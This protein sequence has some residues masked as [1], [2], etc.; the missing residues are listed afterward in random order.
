[1][2]SELVA[3]I[4]EDRQNF[5]PALRILVASLARHS[6]G[7]RLE[8][9]C[10]NASAAF[11]QWLTKYP[12]AN[13]TKA[14]P[15]GIE[16]RKYDI[17]P[18]ALLELLKGGFDNVLWIDSDI[19]LARDC[20]ML[21]AG[22]SRE[23]IVV[24]EE[25]LSGGRSD[26]DGIRARL[27]GMEVGRI[28][29][30]AANT[31]VVRA[32]GAHIP[33]LERWAELLA[34]PTYR[35]AQDRLWAEREIHTMGDQEVLTAV[36]AGSQ[37]SDVPV[38][39]LKRGPDIIQFFGINGY[40]VSERLRH[41]VQ[42]MPPFV[43][44]QGFRPWLSSTTENGFPA[45]IRMLNNELSPYTALAR[46]YSGVLEDTTWLHP[47]STAAAVLTIFGG[48]HAPLV[49]LPIALVADAARTLKCLR[50]SRMNEVKIAAS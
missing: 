9:F 22:L 21:F 45:R 33:L 46:S 37:F 8:L 11:S 29:P 18:H 6:P 13:L 16:W 47:K 27:W 17:K 31:S 44:S 34:S 20:R 50:S 28:L 4:A 32:T 43:H 14:S 41:L 7:M 12:Q 2:N 48:W 15:G 39:F 25:A 42:G 5:E 3:C 40:T 35:N 38:K 36:L 49:G 1:M 23:T 19:L 10:P 26:D 24:S 30:L